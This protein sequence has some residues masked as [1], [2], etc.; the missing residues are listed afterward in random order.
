MI[1]SYI[2]NKIRTKII[3][4]TFSHTDRNHALH[5]AWGHIFNNHL[6]GDY[7][8]FGVYRGDSMLISFKQSEKFKS[9]NKSQLESIEPWR[10]KLA[11]EYLSYEPK[12][13]GFDTFLGLPGNNEKNTIFDTGNFASS[14]ESVRSRLERVIR[15][16]FLKLVQGNFIQLKFS[17]SNLPI[18]ILN[19]D[20][21]LYESALSALRLSEPCLQIGS[22]ILFDDFHAF[23]SDDLKGERRALSEFLKSSSIK[24]DRWFDY[25]YSGRA[26]LITGL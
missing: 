21:D 20:S 14:L 24:V 3:E 8:E 17:P 18:A 12:F 4:V 15:A 10:V 26:F 25:Q 2:K 19:I 5:T 1:K 16:E 6:R 11:K 7:W 23:N 9:W 13:I 22:V